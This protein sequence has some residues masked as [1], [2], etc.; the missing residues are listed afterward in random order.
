LSQSSASLWNPPSNPEG[1]PIHQYEWALPVRGKSAMTF[2]SSCANS[3]PSYHLQTILQVPACISL[4]K[5]RKP[6]CAIT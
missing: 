3:N 1:G 2:S 4:H 6:S 5:Q